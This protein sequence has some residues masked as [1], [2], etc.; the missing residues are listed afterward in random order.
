MT[1][2]V[3]ID[4]VL[5]RTFP[6]SSSPANSLLICLV[7]YQLLKPNT[8]SPRPSIPSSRSFSGDIPSHRNHHWKAQGIQLR[9][10]AE[11][12]HGQ[13]SG[14]PSLIPYCAVHSSGASWKSALARYLWHGTSESCTGLYCCGRVMWARCASGMQHSRTNP[15]T[16][17]KGRDCILKRF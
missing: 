11:R 4:A 9:V 2:K 15:C 8:A 1:H 14:W 7:P 13:S 3:R 16:V 5:C 10:W 17:R 6:C 12:W